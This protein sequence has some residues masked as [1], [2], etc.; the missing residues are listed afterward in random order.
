MK[1]NREKGIKAKEERTNPICKLVKGNT[2]RESSAFPINA[3]QLQLSE[4]ATPKLE[5]RINTTDA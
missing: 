2:Q 1:T 4:A 3:H 5:R